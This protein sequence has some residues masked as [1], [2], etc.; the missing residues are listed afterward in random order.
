MMEVYSVLNDIKY[1]TL[2]NFYIFAGDEWK[3]QQIY[4]EQIAKV[5]N[6]KIKYIN[7]IKD[8][9][10]QLQN[11][12]FIQQKFCY[13]CRDDEVFL[14]TESLWEQ[15]NGIFGDNIYI[16]LLTAIDKRTKFF[17]RF[18]V[19]IC[20]FDPLDAKILQKYIQ[21]E[22]D[23]SAQNC[24]KLME[25]CEYDYG[26]CLLEIDKIKRY[27]QGFVGDYGYDNFFQMLI[28]DGTIYQPPK[29]AVFDLV[30][31]VLKNKINSAFYCL[32]Q[33]YENDEPKLIMLSLLFNNIKA[34]LQV[35]TYQGADLSTATGLSNWEIKLAKGRLNYYDEDYLIYML[36]E[37]QKVEIGIKTGKID[38]DV[39]MEFLLARIM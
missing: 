17:K 10:N 8:V 14:K 35:Q 36:R 27:A 20:I 30:D 6:L 33:C 18:S 1:G 37:V 19:D 4:I 38:E 21:K 15:G 34:V 23:L 5:K 2:R 7:S 12:S 32:R 29:D 26:R 3:V 39:C 24:K 31:A 28:K 25:I 11:K 16:L 13:V 22:I 9:Y